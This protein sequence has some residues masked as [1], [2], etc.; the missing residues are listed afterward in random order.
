MDRM[1]LSNMVDSEAFKAFRRQAYTKMYAFIELLTQA[2]SLTK[3]PRVADLQKL[4]LRMLNT[5]DTKL[6]KYVLEVL[7]KTDA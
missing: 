5:S 3:V 7:L 1:T 4:M 2:E 6:Q